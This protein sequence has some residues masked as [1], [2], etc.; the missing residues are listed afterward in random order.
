MLTALA[1]VVLV[2]RARLPRDLR[3]ALVASV[4][5]SC[6]DCD[7]GVDLDDL[8]KPETETRGIRGFERVL[9]L[10]GEHAAHDVWFE[11]G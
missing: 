1:P 3:T 5:A 10:V 4:N 9:E 6:P 8:L 2:Q 7:Q 11:V